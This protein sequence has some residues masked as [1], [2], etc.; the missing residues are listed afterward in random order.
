M[1]PHPV[2]KITQAQL[3]H[4]SL[5]HLLQQQGMDASTVASLAGATAAALSANG[6]MPGGLAGFMGG[7]MGMMG[8]QGAGGAGGDELAM[9]QQQGAAGFGG[10]STG[11]A[12]LGQQQGATGDGSVSM[13]VSTAGQDPGQQQ[14]QQH[15]LLALVQEAA[16]M[17]A[18]SQQQSQQGAGAGQQ[19]LAPPATDTAGGAGAAWMAVEGGGT[20]A[21]Q[22]QQLAELTRAAG[23]AEGQGQGRAS[24]PGA[25]LGQLGG[26]LTA[27]DSQAG[28]GNEQAATAQQQQQQLDAAGE[29]LM[30]QQMHSSMIPV[31]QQYG[32]QG[33]AGGEEAGAG[34][35]VRERCF[36]CFLVTLPVPNHIPTIFPFSPLA[37]PPSPLPPAG[38]HAEQPAHGPAAAAAAAGAA[39]PFKHAAAEL[40]LG[41]G[42]QRAAAAA[43]YDA[44]W[45]WHGPRL[46]C[47][48]L[49]AAAS[50]LPSSRGAAAAAWLSGIWL[51][52]WCRC[53]RHLSEQS[54]PPSV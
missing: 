24:M 45:R 41:R 37:P 43:G 20:Q 28:P 11:L 53:L 52:A 5:M 16:L 42:T 21:E 25:Q 54:A 17:N 2:P 6:M 34:G 50:R 10:A 51:R 18:S 46:Y 44:A 49:P 3:Q 38:G 8:M 9:Q 33:G 36:G 32:G 19:G 23:E 31:P 1:I 30:Q 13:G 22:Q 47:Q 7:G 4:G 15:S 12:L 40:P 27:S 48:R 26:Q 29:A 14:Q 35:E 39:G